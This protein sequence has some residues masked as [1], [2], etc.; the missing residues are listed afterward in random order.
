MNIIA[1][2]GATVPPATTRP[3]GP[4][5][6][7]LASAIVLAAVALV[8]VRLGGGAFAALVI[9]VALLMAWE[10]DG[11]T[12]GDGRGWTAFWLYTVVAAAPVFAAFGWIGFALAFAGAG[13]IGSAVVARLGARPSGWA[14]LAVPYIVL[15]CIAMIWLHAEFGFQAVI[16]LLAVLWA[17]DSGGYV[18]GRAIG[19]PRLARRISPNKTWAGLI[20]GMAAAAATGWG[21]ALVFAFDQPG[22]LATAAAVLA[23][24]GQAGDLSESAIK[25]HFGAK[26]S[27]NLIPGH[28]GVLDRVDSLLLTAPISVMVLIGGGG[29]LLWR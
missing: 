3:L 13:A 11:L 20:G 25:R 8:C 5:V 28:G 7:R 24:V 6:K 27:S 21:L 26:D 10:W 15:P 9:V 22:L 1:A 17:T 29:G 12:G 2:S 23:I 18:F 19:G 14:V 4:L 16:W